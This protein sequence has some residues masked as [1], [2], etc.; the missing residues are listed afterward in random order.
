MEVDNT[1]LWN[2]LWTDEAHF[3]LQGSVNTRNCRIW[4]RENPFQMQ[5]LPLHSQNVTVWYGF[6]AAFIVGPFSFEEIGP[7][8]PVT[9]TDNGTR[10]DLFLRNQ[11]ITALQQRGCVVSTIF[12]QAGAHPH[13]ATS[14]KQ[15]LNLHF[16]NNRIISR[17]FPT[18][19][20]TRSPNLNLCDFWLWGN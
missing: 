3:H 16:G 13:I 2:I 4:V 6:T 19:W 12:M 9:C 1:W 7:S 15:L 18:D 11:L 5:P 20:Q 14:V 17:H 8:G 10:Y